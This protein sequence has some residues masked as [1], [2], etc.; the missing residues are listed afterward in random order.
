MAKT[1]IKP[2]S[3]R[4]WSCM[5]NGAAINKPLMTAA[6][7][8]ERGECTDGLDP[9]DPCSACIRDNSRAAL[10]YEWKCL[11]AKKAQYRVCCTRSRACSRLN[12]KVQG[13]DGIEKTLARYCNFDLV[14]S[15]LM[16]Y[17]PPVYVIKIVFYLVFFTW[18]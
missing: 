17:H 11:S 1:A 12:V 6:M 18:M 15:L 14:T 7:N 10:I 4:P 8:P 5:D 9:H 3:H 16:Y 2:I 13:K